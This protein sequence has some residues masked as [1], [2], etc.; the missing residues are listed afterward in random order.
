MFQV[1]IQDSLTSASSYKQL[2]ANRRF[3]NWSVWRT[4][5]LD[6]HDTI[7]VFWWVPGVKTCKRVEGRLAAGAFSVLQGLVKKKKKSLLAYIQLNLPGTL[8]YRLIFLWN[9][10]S[11]IKTFEEPELWRRVE[12]SVQH[13][14]QY[15]NPRSDQWRHHVLTR[16]VK[17]CVWWA[18]TLPRASS[19]MARWSH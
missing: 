16:K 14:N 17:V 12:G 4:C 15:K 1:V 2:Q 13:S 11:T 18:W 8:Q 10:R 3:S 19:R 9:C 5:G 7:T 6:V